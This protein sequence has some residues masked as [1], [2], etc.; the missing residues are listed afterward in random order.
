MEGF[1]DLPSKECAVEDQ[2]KRVV[3]GVFSTCWMQDP[4]DD[5]QTINEGLGWTCGIQTKNFEGDE[6][7][8][9]E[10][11]ILLTMTEKN[12]E[13]VRKTMSWATDGK[14][15]PAMKALRLL[16]DGG[17]RLGGGTEVLGG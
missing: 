16:F 7:E 12:A 6:G 14:E 3:S 17:R 5:I 8:V 10:K 2:M 1:T 4:E 15:V 11:M 13:K 9:E